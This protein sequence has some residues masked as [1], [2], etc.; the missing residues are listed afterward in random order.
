MRRQWVNV[1]TN[2]SLGEHVAGVFADNSMDS[3]PV[4]WLSPARGEALLEGQ[5]DLLKEVV[6]AGKYV[7]FNGLRYALTSKGVVHDDFDP[8]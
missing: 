1:V 3:P 7:I 8:L 4:G 5:Q 2:A 6:D